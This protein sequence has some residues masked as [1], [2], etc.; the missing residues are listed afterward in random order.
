MR[1]QSVDIVIEDPP[2]SEDDDAEKK[3]NEEQAHRY[4]DMAA[5]C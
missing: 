1:T 2:E 3:P 4:A 5:A